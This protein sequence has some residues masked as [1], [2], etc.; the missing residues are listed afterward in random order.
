M[1]SCLFE[2]IEKDLSNGE[3]GYEAAISNGCL[4]YNL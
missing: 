4:V 3:L 2:E 1:L